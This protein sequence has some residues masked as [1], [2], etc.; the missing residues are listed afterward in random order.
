MNLQYIIGNWKMN[1]TASQGKVFWLQLE[2]WLEAK[3]TS[4]LVVGI[5]APF[6]NI[7]ALVELQKKVKIGAQNVA[8]QEKGAYTGEISNLML[9]DS[10]VDFCLVGHSERRKYFQE[11]DQEIN[12][13]I[14]Q[15][16]KANITPILCLGESE[17]QFEAQETR[18]VIENQL[19]KGLANIAATDLVKIMIAYEPVW[20]IGTGKSATAQIAQE[21][22]KI[23]RNKVGQMANQQI[24]NQIPLLYGG[25]VKEG[26][27]SQILDQPDINGVLVGGASLQFE[28]FSNLIVSRK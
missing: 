16:L 8:S 10:Q 17:Q 14:Q 9:T 27:I 19:S 21:V 28:D 2:K 12:L 23:I 7:P 18:V 1:K 13:K 4:D 26:N 20:A 11:S 15:L 5:A 6:L 22:I 24:S 25:S 3:P